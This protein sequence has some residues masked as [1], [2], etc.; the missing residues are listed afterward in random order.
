MDELKLLAGS[1]TKM[2]ITT[3]IRVAIAGITAEN[4]DVR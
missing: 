4:S 2:K 3:R 1:D